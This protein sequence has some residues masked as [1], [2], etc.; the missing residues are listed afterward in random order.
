MTKISQLQL[1]LLA[2]NREQ[3]TTFEQRALIARVI[4]AADPVQLEIIADA[5]GI[6]ASE[7]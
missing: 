1:D 4:I 7:D 3:N 5:L 6:K 2:A